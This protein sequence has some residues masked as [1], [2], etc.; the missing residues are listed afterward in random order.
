[1]CKAGTPSKGRA[2][3]QASELHP[4]PVR[5]PAHTR[6]HRPSGPGCQPSPAPIAARKPA[7]APFKDRHRPAGGLYPQG[8]RHKTSRV[9][10]ID[11]HP[12]QSNQPGMFA[13]SLFHEASGSCQIPLAPNR[14]G[15]TGGG[16]Q[17][18]LVLSAGPGWVSWGSE[19]EGGGIRRSWGLCPRSPA[20]PRERMRAARSTPGASTGSR[21]SK[22]AVAP[23]RVDPSP[24]RTNFRARSQNPMTLQPGLCTDHQGLGEDSPFR[25]VSSSDVPAWPRVKTPQGE[26]ARSH[27]RGGPDFSCPHQQSAAG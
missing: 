21:W 9:L 3:T 1:M 25:A 23:S 24:D 19:P 14:E 6:L 20:R 4:G 5:G 10:F 12:T 16:A 7:L 27:E 15:Q 18:R 11:Q 22:Q 17:T 13:V 8:D 26:E 2:H